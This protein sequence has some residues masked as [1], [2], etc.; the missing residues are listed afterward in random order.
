MTKRISVRIMTKN[1][2]PYIVNY[3]QSAS[4]DYLLTMGAMIEKIPSKETMSLFLEGQVRL[5]DDKKESFCAIWLL[6]NEPIGHCNV[7]TITYGKQATMH[8]H[9]WNSLERNRG[10]GV[11]FVKLSLKYFFKQLKLEKVVCE[12]YALN[13]APNRTLQK[14]GFSFVKEYITIPGSLNFEQS[15]KQWS[16]TREDFME[17]IY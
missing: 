10:Y 9:A 15:V 7:N 13:D 1:D 5:S 4:K 17:R 11:Q 6:D 2:V 3:W 16:L 8:L 14:A 12:P